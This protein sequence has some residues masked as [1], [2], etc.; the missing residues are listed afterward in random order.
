MHKIN[1]KYSLYR[2]VI[3]KNLKPVLE[4]AKWKEWFKWENLGY[5]DSKQLIKNLSNKL[6]FAI[7]K[8]GK[9]R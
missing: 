3:L 8:F 5:F 2:R 1:I 6:I 9:E 7:F 4:Y